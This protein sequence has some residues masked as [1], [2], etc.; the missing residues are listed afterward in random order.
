MN[1]S[2]P[3][4]LESFIQ[5][6]GEIT[7]ASVEQCIDAVM[8]EQE[9]QWDKEVDD[10]DRLAAVSEEVSRFSVSWA[11]ERARTDE[12]EA[13]RIYKHMEQKYKVT[14][15]KCE[16]PTSLSKS[17]EDGRDDHKSMCSDLSHSG[18]ESPRLTEHQKTKGASKPP[19]KMPK[20]PRHVS[21]TIYR[22][23]SPMICS[24]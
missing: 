3:R 5:E 20:L 6:D 21:I 14:K 7:T 22:K 17:I 18:A 1:E 19:L 12:K 23:V 24:R 4:G 9:V 2:C 16:S 15:S 10:Y 11:L 8:D 13:Q